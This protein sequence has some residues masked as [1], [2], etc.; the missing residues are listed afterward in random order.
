MKKQLA[1]GTHCL[2]APRGSWS[3]A[4]IRR[5]NEDGTYKIEYD[6]KDMILMPYWYGVTI[7]ELSVDDETRWSDV[8]LRVTGSQ[9]DFSRADLA[10]V[11]ARLGY[12]VTEDRLIEFW[13][14]TC[15]TLFEFAPDTARDAHVDF[16]QAYQIIRKAGLSAKQVGEYFES[17]PRAVSYFKLYWNQTRM[18]GRDPS[19][20]ARSITADD[21]YAALGVQGD[22][23]DGS[24]AQALEAWQMR[25]GILLPQLLTTFLTRESIARGVRDCHPNNPNLPPFDGS[26][27]RVESAMRD[28]GV[29]GNFAI[30]LMVPHQGD[31]AWF[32]V[33]DEGDDDARICVGPL[34]DD[35]ENQSWI[36]TA[37]TIAFFF[38]DLA[39]TGL[40]WFE[41]TQFGGGKPTIRTD[42]G[43]ALRE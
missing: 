20:V 27:F 11:L 33:F 24:A 14:K 5:L 30:T 16:A 2:A 40:C 32:A 12:S 18:G 9:N 42:I 41:D 7:S 15:G 31:H 28:R 36:L 37:P 22:R 3:G 8:A 26:D 29:P 34:D 1:E 39:Q 25:T 4:I 21:A 6:E 19:E 13:V 35:A 43:L 17:E 23:V 10:A 38:W